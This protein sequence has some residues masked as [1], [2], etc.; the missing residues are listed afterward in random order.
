MELYFHPEPITGNRLILHP[1]EAQ[2]VLKTRRLRSGDQFWLSC[3]DGY[4]HIVQ[5]V[6]DNLKSPEVAILESQYF[7]P[8]SPAIHLYIAPLKQEARFEWL[9]EKAV[10][11]GVV[12][13]Q[14]L[15]TRR[16]EKVHLRYNRLEK[17]VV[18]AMKQSL[19]YHKTQLFEAKPLPDC[20]PNEGVK[21][22]AHCESGPKQ[23]IQAAI[24]TAS[25]IHLF[26]GPEGDFHPE[27]IQWARKHG[28]VEITLGE[29]RLRTETAGLVG[30]A[31][32]HHSWQIMSS[33]V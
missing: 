6:N 22:L 15:L 26:I 24:L 13:I 10:E 30:L 9:V 8:L 4:R 14:P 17:I 2:H 18:S 5:L 21:L 19:K 7:E 20:M 25:P 33:N 16:T 27:E 28:F 1:D 23:I 32:I 12:S 3:G 29:A 31:Q 11:L